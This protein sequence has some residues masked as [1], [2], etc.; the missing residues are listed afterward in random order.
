MGWN[1]LILYIEFL[2]GSSSQLRADASR[3]KRLERRQARTAFLSQATLEA[4][5]L[6]QGAAGIEVGAAG[7]GRRV[8]CRHYL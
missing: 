7:G 2:A 1:G 6:R 4:D 3:L 8:S 5:V